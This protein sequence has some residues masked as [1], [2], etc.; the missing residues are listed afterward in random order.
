MPSLITWNVSFLT[1][2]IYFNPFFKL[3]WFSVFLYISLCFGCL[4]L[5]PNIAHINCGNCHTT[6]MYPYGAPSVKCAV[7]QYITNVNVS[8]L[9]CLSICY[10][11]FEVPWVSFMPLFIQS[12]PTQFFFLNLIFKHL[13][14]V[15]LL[16][17]LVPT[18]CVM[19]LSHCFVLADGKC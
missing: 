19:L 8:T 9:T 17:H 18:P 14:G 2:Q 7:C 10:W 12:Y 16:D 11:K 4:L 5:A 1:S 15:I 6:L 13:F 3:D